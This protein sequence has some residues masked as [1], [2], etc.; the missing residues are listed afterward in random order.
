MKLRHKCCTKDPDINQKKQILKD[1]QTSLQN[2]NIKNS[3]RDAQTIDIGVVYHVCYQNYD[4]T[5]VDADIAHVNNILNKDF[6]MNADNFNNGANVYKYTPPTVKLIPYLP[7][8][9]QLKYLRITS[10]IRQKYL[11]RFG[12]NRRRYRRAIR[13]ISRRYARINR[14]RRR[15]NI[16]INRINRARRRINIRR[17]RINMSR[18]ALINKYLEIDRRIATYDN[19]YK[20]YVSLAGNTNIQFNHVQTVYHPVQ[21]ISTDNLDTIDQIVKING[22]PAIQTNKY[23]NV[24]I[25]NM[26]NGILGYAQFPWELQSK[27]LTDGVV[28][29]RYA[30]GRT[31]AY[32][33]YN[34]NKTI[35]HEIGHWLG[36]YHTFQYTFNNQEG[37]F[38]NNNDNIISVSER[39]GD[40]VSDTP[41]QNTPTYGNPYTN[42]RTWP[43]TVYNGT[44]YY[45]MYLNYMDYT[46]DVNMFMFTKEQSDKIRLM[47]N[48]YR[49]DILV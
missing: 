12:R 32:S 33:S 41:L 37:I 10:A 18:I 1:L 3:L 49:P 16:R 39:T 23:L 30:F 46:D 26:T 43:S 44:R 25:V 5:S 8:R 15:S 9:S 24:W 13:N 7:Y 35:I 2:N 22:S 28:V 31:P 20:N 29:N 14:A 27:P 38:D 19:I 6:N 40:L 34:L 17:R 11:R 45:H 48:H 47:I 42:N 36:L 21:N 4:K